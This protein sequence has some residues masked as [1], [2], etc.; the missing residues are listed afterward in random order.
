MHNS[1]LNYNRS[2]VRGFERLAFIASVVIPLGIIV[3]CS[4]YQNITGYFNTYYNAKKLFDEAINDVENS[5]QRA[6][7]TLYFVGYVSNPATDAKFD[8]VIEKCSKIIQFYEKS[9]WVDDAILMIG[10]SYVYKGESESAVRKFGE[11]ADK[12]PNSNLRRKTKLWQAKAEY[13]MK[14]EDE[15][16]KIT[17]DLFD[18]ARGE[19]DND[20]LFEMLMLDGQIAYDRGEYDVAAAKYELASE[21]S[22]DNQLRAKAKYL[23]GYAY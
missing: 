7:D 2:I 11:L 8:K 18:E 13:F 19:G 12:F 22:V 1:A 20:V 9:S 15:A 6:R 21:T 3:G 10:I 4:T 17:K 5:P 23:C 14:K 16:L